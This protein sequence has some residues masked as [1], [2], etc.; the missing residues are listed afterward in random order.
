MWVGQG[1][2]RNHDRSVLASVPYRTCRK[3]SPRVPSRRELENA[4][5]SRRTQG[6]CD[7]RGRQ[8]ARRSKGSRSPSSSPACLAHR[9]SGIPSISTLTNR[10][11]RTWP[12]DAHAACATPSSPSASHTPQA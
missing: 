2:A 1:R 6:K 4:A 7:C 12:P 11:Q 8:R 3:R 9:P 5:D 10:L